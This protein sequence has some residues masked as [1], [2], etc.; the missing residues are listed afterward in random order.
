[1]KPEA[2]RSTESRTKLEKVFCS[3]SS[4]KETFPSLSAQISATGSDRPK[5]KP[6]PDSLSA[7]LIAVIVAVTAGTPRVLTLGQ[8]HA[9]PS[10][11]FESGQRSLQATLRN[12]VELQTE[13]RLGYVEQL[14]TFADSD[15]GGE[16]G[17]RT[18]SISYLGL[19]R[20]SRKT[21]ANAAWHSWY[22]YFPWEDHREGPPSLLAEKVLPQIQ[23]WAKTRAQKNR[24]AI[25]FGFD[26]KIWNE[27]LVLS[28]YELLF[29]A[30]LVPEWV[31]RHPDSTDPALP[32]E[33]M[34]LDH[35]RI[36][37]TAIARLRTKIKYRPVFFELMP[38]S[39]T[40]LQ[41]QQT[42]EAIAG[43]KLHKQNFRRQIDADGMVEE[44]GAI[45]TETG[46]RP[47]KLFRYR[48]DLQTERAIEGT[49]LP[50]ARP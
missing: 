25:N 1:M 35:R 26:G 11:S 34:D 3:F 28:R 39:F 22:R 15:R 2:H 46:G 32:G 27:E 9:L 13:Q 20:E 49:K 10:G 17:G 42:V 12:W 8:G 30:G 41:L 29:E 37:A 33:A 18:I 19:G 14:Y 7:E 38:E 47:A 50:L 31:R 40:L 24:A 5:G 36:L 6:V 45:T 16:Q 4:E 23:A 21:A 48:R 43:R 44:T